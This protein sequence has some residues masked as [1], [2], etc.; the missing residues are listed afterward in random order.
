MQILLLMFDFYYKKGAME[1]HLEMQSLSI[2]VRSKC[3]ENCYEG[4]ITKIL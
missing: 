3:R 2:T 1:G 4:L